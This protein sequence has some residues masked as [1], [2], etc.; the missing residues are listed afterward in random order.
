MDGLADAMHGVSL[1]EPPR[2][3]YVNLT[4]NDLHVYDTAGQRRVAF[5]PKGDAMARVNPAY[6][7]VEVSAGGVPHLRVSSWSVGGLPPPRE[8]VVYV[9]NAVVAAAVPLRADV[10]HVGPLKREGYT[11]VGCCGLVFN[12]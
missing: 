3:T 10:A 6:E 7:E 11:V 9:V 1:A 4:Q 2:P 12:A 8:G 5:L